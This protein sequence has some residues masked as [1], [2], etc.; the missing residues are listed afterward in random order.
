MFL[1][2]LIAAIL[3]M[4]VLA[5]VSFS[6]TAA[7]T[8]TIKSEPAS[9]VWLNGVRYGVTDSTGTFEIK[10]APVGKQSIKVRAQGFRESTKTLLPAQKGTIEIPLT[11]TTDDGEL[12]FQEA[13]RLSGIDRQRAAA[14]YRNAI[15]L[16]PGNVDAHVGLARV[17]SDSGDFEGAEKAIRQAVKLDPR[18]PEAAAVDGR[19]QKLSGDESKAIAAFKKAI[20]NGGGFQPEAYTGLGIL[21]QDRAEAAAGEGDFAGELKNY[22]EAAKNFAVAVKQ[23]GTAPDAPVVIQLLGLVYEKQQKYKEAIALYENFLK[24]FPDSTESTAIRSF[25]VQLKK[26]LAEQ[27]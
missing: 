5:C 6:Q 24:L 10:N 20:M 16:K 25:I 12:A 17:L 19:I 7:R 15:R 22:A 4:I 1:S 8:L 21:Y 13:E 3:L 18:H 11:K 27:N 14:A 26:Q 23:L 2:K 9:T